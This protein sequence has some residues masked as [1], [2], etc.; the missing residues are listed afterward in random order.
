MKK[1]SKAL[2]LTLVSSVLFFNPA[3]ANTLPDGE[4]L[5]KLVNALDEGAFTTRK[6]HMKTIDRRNKER[7]TERALHC[8]PPLHVPFTICAGEMCGSR[9]LALPLPACILVC[10]GIKALAPTKSKEH[11]QALSLRLWLAF[12]SSN[13]RTVL[14]G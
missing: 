10:H 6:I 11:A 14:N 13:P 2:A 9:Y 1:F 7:E 4:A 8:A 5:V 12:G 3:S